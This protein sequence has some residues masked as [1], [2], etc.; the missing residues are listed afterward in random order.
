MLTCLQTFHVVALKSVARALSRVGCLSALWLV[1]TVL[2]LEMM[3]KLE[4]P[5]ESALAVP[6]SV[7]PSLRQSLEL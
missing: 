3:Y 7:R 1:V 6:Q 4:P 2:W 5:V